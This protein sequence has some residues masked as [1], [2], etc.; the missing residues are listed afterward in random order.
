MQLEVNPTNLLFSV[1]AV[2]IG[3]LSEQNL[4]SAMNA[5]TVAIKKKIIYGELL[6]L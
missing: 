6:F 1:P 4:F 5:S 3:L 2:L